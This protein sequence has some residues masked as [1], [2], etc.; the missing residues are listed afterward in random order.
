MFEIFLRKHLSYTTLTVWQ[1]FLTQI[2]LVVI[3]FLPVLTSHQRLILFCLE[4]AEVSLCLIIKRF[5]RK[6]INL[7]TMEV[8]YS[9]TT[10]SKLLPVINPS[11]LSVSFWLPLTTYVI[12]EG[13]KEPLVRDGM[14]IF[15]IAQQFLFLVL[16][17][18]TD[19]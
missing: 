10:L 7:K 11:F 17:P 9:H 3:Y 18:R 19:H 4:I 8:L 1:Y 16:D 15:S 12:W 14:C 13:R 5:Q 6:K 2:A